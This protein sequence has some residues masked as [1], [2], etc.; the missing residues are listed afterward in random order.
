MIQALSSKADRAFSEHD[1]M[2]MRAQVEAPRLVVIGHG[3]TTRGCERI[4]SAEVFRVEYDVHRTEVVRDL[5]ERA[6]ANDRRGHAGLR[7]TPAQSK[8]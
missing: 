1:S 2:A 7:R 4:D 3:R 6:R 5:L 8:L